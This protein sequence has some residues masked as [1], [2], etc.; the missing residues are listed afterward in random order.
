LQRY[1]GKLSNMGYGLDASAA[2][3]G[4]VGR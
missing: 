3:A 2:R 4:A 1:L